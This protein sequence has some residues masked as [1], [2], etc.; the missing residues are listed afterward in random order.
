MNV[1]AKFKVT[2]VTEFESSY[3]EK[4]PDGTYKYRQGIGNK[5]KFY[6]VAADKPEN[7]TFAQWSP[8]GEL[9]VTIVN[10]ALVGHFK[11]GK[12]YIFDINEA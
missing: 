7:E 6:V 4:Q 12:E 11:V 1:K 10:P 9:T 5:V 8:T 2:E 3:N